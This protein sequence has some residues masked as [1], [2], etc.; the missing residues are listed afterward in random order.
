MTRFNQLILLSTVNKSCST[1]YICNL[2]IDNKLLF[3]L[4]PACDKKEQVSFWKEV[5]NYFDNES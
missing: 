5:S 2:F 1:V 4:Q 3:I